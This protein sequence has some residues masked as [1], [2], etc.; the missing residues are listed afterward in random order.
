MSYI[1]QITGVSVLQRKAKSVI[2][3]AHDSQA[4][5][6][7]AEHNNIKAVL[8]DIQQYEEMMAQMDRDEGLFWQS[9][10]EAGLSFWEDES[11]DA[12]NEML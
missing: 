11:N 1:P 3:Q 2:N 7:L 12:Y 6:F 8:L 4:P 5:V 10:Q 9:A